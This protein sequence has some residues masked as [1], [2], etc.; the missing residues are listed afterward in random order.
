M[1][2]SDLLYRQ[3]LLSEEINKTLINFKKDGP[4]R[5]T[6]DHI[7]RRL[8]SLERYWNEYTSNH[9]K[10]S[11][12][13]TADDEYFVGGYYQQTKQSYMETKLYIEKSSISI[14]PSKYPA[15]VPPM[16]SQESKNFSQ[17][18]QQ[19]ESSAFEDPITT[20]ERNLRPSKQD[21]NAMM[22]TSDAGNYSKLDEKFKKQLSILR[23]LQQPS[24]M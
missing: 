17:E 21:W 3:A 15:S 23:R 16:T 13:L 19:D 4:S 7:K 6:P 12:C 14:T 1:D 9:A 18:A 11:E 10:L 8:E 2:M 24:P 22:N 5:R 20:Q